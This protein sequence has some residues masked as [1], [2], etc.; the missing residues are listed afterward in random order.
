MQRTLSALAH[1]LRGHGCQARRV[2]VRWV[3]VC[4]I[5]VRSLM[6][7][8][9]VCCVIMCTGLS[10][11]GSSCAGSSCTVLSCAWSSMHSAASLC[12]G[13]SRA[14]LFPRRVCCVIVCCVILCRVVMHGV[15]MRGV[16]MRCVV[17]C[18][19]VRAGSLCMWVVVPCVVV[20]RVI[21][22]CIV[23]HVGWYGWALR[24][25]AQVRRVLRRSLVVCAASSCTASSSVKTK[26]WTMVGRSPE[27]VRRGQFWVKLSQKTCN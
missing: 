8:V 14:V 25:H 21:V 23:V 10:F 3:T 7:C 19:V 1:L 12:S 24:C 27:V 20:H 18:I 5:I 13:S 4:V 16:V 17:C 9:V 11:P 22:P 6:C 26:S 2:M 15:I